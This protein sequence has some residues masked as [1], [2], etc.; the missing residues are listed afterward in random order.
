MPEDVTAAELALQIITY[1]QGDS[2]GSRP[3]DHWHFVPSARPWPGG[4]P[5]TTAEATAH[6]AAM[7]KPMIIGALNEPGMIAVWRPGHFEPADREYV[8]RLLHNQCDALADGATAIGA[9]DSD[10]VLFEGA[11]SGSRVTVAELRTML[12]Q[13]G[14]TWGWRLGQPSDDSHSFRLLVRRR[15]NQWSPGEECKT[16]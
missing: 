12:G 6:L 9:G 3:I 15:E 8:E 13:Y 5:F 11:S 1:L 16:G 2:S 7:D 10:I 4:P 14:W